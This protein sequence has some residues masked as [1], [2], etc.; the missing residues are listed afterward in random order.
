MIDVLQEEA[1]KYP[2]DLVNLSLICN[3]ASSVRMLAAPGCRGGKAT[4]GGG[5][6][7]D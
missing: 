2:K 1:E 5:P 4:H 6:E 3:M 7:D